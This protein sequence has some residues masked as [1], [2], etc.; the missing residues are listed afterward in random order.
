M[1]R[2]F[3]DRLKAILSAGLHDTGGQLKQKTRPTRSRVVYASQYNAADVQ[4]LPV[5]LT[6][7]SQPDAGKGPRGRVVGEPSGQ[8]GSVLPTS[9]GLHQRWE[10]REDHQRD[11]YAR[12]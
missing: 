7:T 8:L 11:S 5:T 1:C 4:E 9:V 6:I 2:N 3:Q 10:L 12:G